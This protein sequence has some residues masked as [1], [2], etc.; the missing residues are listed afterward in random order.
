MTSHIYYD[1][2][3]YTR[4]CEYVIV[5][6]CHVIFFGCHYMIY[7]P[8]RYQNITHVYIYM[9]AY[10]NITYYNIALFAWQTLPMPHTHTHD[11]TDHRHNMHTMHI[12]QNV[13]QDNAK[14]N[15]IPKHK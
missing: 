7:V 11:N 15:T 10:N 4:A 13:L 5:L 9:Y 8:H 12:R 6:L 2:D 14:F 3:P 1:I